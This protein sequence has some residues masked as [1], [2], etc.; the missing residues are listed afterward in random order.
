MTLAVKLPLAPV[1]IAQALWARARVPRLPEA[2]GPREGV[3]GRGPALALLIVG[4]SSAAGVG[5][6]TQAQA[7]AG[8]LAPTLARRAGVA[9]HWR[10]RARSGVNTAAALE[11]LDDEP[12]DVAVVVT[13]VNDV[14][15]QVAPAKALA[16]RERL[17]DALRRRQ[18]V[19]HVVW[20]PVPP[21]GAFRGLPQP[22]RWV[23]GL[24]ARAHDRALAAWAASREGCSVL[25][26]QLPVQ[27]TTL[28]ASD[29]F[30]PGAPMYRRWGEALAEH[31]AGVIPSFPETHP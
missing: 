14:V 31:I 20:S 25:P 18:R 16:A 24:D 9:V 8:R 1:L 13:G 2:E 15:D 7:L 5:V 11:L 3:V 21:M 26:L 6:R 4:D 30:H 28:L 17:L 23:T 19:R 10:L 27:D 29:G 22:L 12:A